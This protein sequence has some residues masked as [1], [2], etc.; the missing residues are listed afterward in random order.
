MLNFRFARDEVTENLHITERALLPTFLNRLAP[1][2]LKIKQERLE[3]SLVKQVTCVMPVAVRERL[4][5]LRETVPG[6]RRLAIMGNVDNPASVL[7]MA[8]VHAAARTLGLDAAIFEIRGAEDLG[9][10]GFPDQAR[11]RPAPAG[12]K[13]SFA[14]RGPCS[15]L[16]AG[17]VRRSRASVAEARH[18]QASAKER[19]RPR[20]RP[21][22]SSAPA[23]LRTRHTRGI[24]ASPAGNDPIHA[25][26]V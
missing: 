12:D 9:T 16:L 13:R 22:L 14:P 3:E 1:M 25:L 2:G 8:K 18:A 15:D 20:S 26:T 10:S 17:L 11:Q 21:G 5:I 6:L 4:Q 23:W 19:S 24:G 7:D